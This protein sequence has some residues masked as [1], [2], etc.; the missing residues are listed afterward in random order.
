MAYMVRH[1]S[2]SGLLVGLLGF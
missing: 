2:S 1:E